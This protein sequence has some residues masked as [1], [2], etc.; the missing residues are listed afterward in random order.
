MRILTNRG[1]FSWGCKFTYEY[2]IEVKMG[3]LNAFLWYLFFFFYL[4]ALIC[5]IRS[6][7][8]RN[9]SGKG[10]IKTLYKYIASCCYLIQIQ[11]YYLRSYKNA[12]NKKNEFVLLHNIH[13]QLYKKLKKKKKLNQKNILYSFFYV[14]I[15]E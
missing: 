2:I 5:I 11:I 12:Y 6:S 10:T 15:F 9:L 3:N 8:A 13:C 4:F 1:R 14:T 7:I